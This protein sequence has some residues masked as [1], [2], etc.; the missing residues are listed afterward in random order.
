MVKDSDEQ[1]WFVGVLFLF[2]GSLWQKGETMQAT[3]K[4]QPAKKK[5]VIASRRKCQAKGTGLS[6]YILMDKKT[7]S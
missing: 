7:K 6:H 5:D 3:R 4:K 1:R 2:R